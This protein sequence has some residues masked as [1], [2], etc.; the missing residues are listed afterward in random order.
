MKRFL[1]ILFAFATIGMLSSVALAVNGASS[2]NIVGSGERAA[3]DP[4]QSFNASAGN[5]T[6]LLIQGDTVTQTWQGYFGNV[7]GTIQ[8][9][10]GSGNVMYNW[11]AANPSG[12]VLASVNQTVDWANIA[13]AGTS[14]ITTLESRYNVGTSVDGVDETFSG[15]TGS[16]TVANTALS[17]CR[18]TTIYD[19]TG[20]SGV[21]FEELLLWDGD[22]AVFASILE[23]DALGFDN[24]THDFQMMVLEDGHAGDTLETT[25]YFFVELE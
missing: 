2:V 19:E 15:T 14:D 20:S 5:V 11:S 9:A 1:F 13:C 24:V 17:G 3:S 21:D 16:V 25:Y 4:A 6:E 8:L 18:N 22:A 10:D 7:S 12:E 23:Q